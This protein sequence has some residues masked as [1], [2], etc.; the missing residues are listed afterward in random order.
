MR[1]KEIKQK[2]KETKMN[3]TD[4]I[5]I[6]NELKQREKVNRGNANARLNHAERNG[7]RKSTKDA[8]KWVHAGAKLDVLNE[9]LG[10]L[11]TSGV[12]MPE[13]LEAEVTA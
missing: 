9:L 5:T 12:E 2:I 10:I 7:L 3:T 1:N 4:F 8:R 13:Q 6:I 11:E